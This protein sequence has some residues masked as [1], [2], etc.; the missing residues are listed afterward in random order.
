L[1]AVPLALRLHNI[2]SGVDACAFGDTASHLPAAWYW[3]NI[4]LPQRD[5]ICSVT[6]QRLNGL[7]KHRNHSQRVCGVNCCWVRRN[8]DQTSHMGCGYN[9]CGAVSVF[10][11]A[12]DKKGYSI[13]SSGCLGIMSSHSEQEGIVFASEIGIV[14]LP[15]AVAVTVTASRLKR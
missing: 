7:D 14:L 5:D 3:Q 11:C 4:S 8:G 9:L 15:A 6:F 13:Y 12:C 10:G 1:L 2:Q